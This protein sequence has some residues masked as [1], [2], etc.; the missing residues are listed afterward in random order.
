M[1]AKRLDRALSNCAW[2]NLFPEAYLENLYRFHS[3]HR[4]IILRCKGFITEKQAR[5]F[6]FQAAWLTH[7]EFPSM[8]EQAWAKGNHYVPA[9]LISVQADATDFN[10]KTFGNIFCRKRDLES[11]LK[12]AQQRLETIDSISLAALEA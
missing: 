12:S 5:P 8:V 4:P 6:C 11:R 7:K 3:D 1:V 2:L 9:S 10:V